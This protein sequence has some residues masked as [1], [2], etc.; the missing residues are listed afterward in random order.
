MQNALLQNR[1]LASCSWT[2]TCLAACCC[3]SHRGN[4]D[5]VQN[6]S[7]LTFWSRTYSTLQAAS[8]SC[9]IISSI[10]VASTDRVRAAEVCKAW[11]RL[12]RHPDTWTTMEYPRKQLSHPLPPH[13]DSHIELEALHWLTR[14]Y[15]TRILHI[16]VRA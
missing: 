8:L 16:E 11:D 4:G 15:A 3:S 10:C 7:L 14:S 13:N 12:L 9:M 1:L 6:L 5:D 2:T